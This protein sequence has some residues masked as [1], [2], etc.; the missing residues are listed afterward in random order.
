MQVKRTKA[1]T[2]ASS[3]KSQPKTESKSK[4]DDSS[5]F[6]E[7]RSITEHGVFLLVGDIDESNT[8]DAIKFI[9]SA[10]LDPDC[11]WDHMTMIIN[12]P[13]GYCTD[14]FA[15]I[16][17]M[18][19]SSIPI[20]TVGL[21][22]I[23]SMGLMTFLAGEKGHR[24]LTPNCMILSHQYTGGTFG[25]EHELVASQKEFDILGEII[26]RHYKRTTGLSKD[27][28]DE[29][30]LP[31]QDVWLTAKEAQKYGICDNVKDLKP[32]TI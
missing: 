13:G 22:Q 28:I 8:Q 15:L 1:A 12:S 5:K 7:P 30:L 26:R 2:K 16:D 9:L 29:Y 20:H 3:P 4:K 32:K 31:S 24:T 11:C 27:E 18:F 17:V 14:G 10:N 25:K 21:G 19:G 6:S 23:S